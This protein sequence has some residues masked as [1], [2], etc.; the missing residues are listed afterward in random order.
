MPEF[1]DSPSS[2]PALTLRELRLLAS[3]LG[4]GRYAA[5]TRNSLVEAIRGRIGRPAEAPAAV[6]P[7]PASAEGA[8]AEVAVQE[9]AAPMAA[10][11]VDRSSVVTT[12]EVAAAVPEAV[13]SVP[14]LSSWVVFAPQDDRW[15]EVRWRI[16][17]A[18]RE[19]A[20]AAGATDLCLRLGDVT[21]L[22]DGDALPHALQEVVVDARGE[23]WYLPIP[24]GGR[25][26]RVELGFRTGGA[27]GWFS[28]AIS[29]GAAVPAS[30]LEPDQTG[31]PLPFVLSSV[32]S[33]DAPAASLPTGSGLHERLYQVASSGIRRLGLGSEAFQEHDSSAAGAGVGLQASGEGFW[34]SGR[35]ESGA[36]GVGARQRRF[37]LV[38]DAELIVHAATEPSALLKVGDAPHPLSEEGTI[39]IHVPFPDGE[40]HYPITAIA[41]DGEQKRNITLSF[42]RGTPVARVNRPEEAVD[43]WF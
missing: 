24:V 15:A 22:A 2:L 18:D 12:P 33:A 34:A 1:R 38:A 14:S 5:L 30:T 37:W 10:A 23:Q 8:A 9:V 26:Y 20:L 28:V 17:D 41:A 16:S 27:G 21:G 13:P 11:P 40:Q 31:A 36:G 29:P 19:Q 7:S 3:R 32:S 43:E 42:Q 25:S 35:Q 6:D 4:L 39:R